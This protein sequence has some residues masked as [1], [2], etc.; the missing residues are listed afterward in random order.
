MANILRKQ[1]QM[2]SAGGGGGSSEEYTDIDYEDWVELTPTEQESGKYYIHGAPG[3]DGDISVELMTKLWENSSPTSAF[4]GQDITGLTNLNDYSLLYIKFK[5]YITNTDYHDFVISNDL[6]MHT[7]SITI[8]STIAGSGAVVFTRS[9]TPDYEN[10]KITFSNGTQCY[11]GYAQ[12]TDNSHTIPI[13]IYGIKTTA[14]AKINVIATDVSTSADKCMLSDGV[15]SVEDALDGFRF[16]AA[17][18]SIVGLVS[19][20]SPYTDSDG[21][22]ILAN[23][24]TGQ[25]MID[26]VTYKSIVSTEDTRG[27]VGADT[28]TPFKKGGGGG[29]TL[30]GTYSGN[31][32]IDVSEYLQ[33]GDTVDN[34]IVEVTGWT[35]G[36]TSQPPISSKA[37]YYGVLAATTIGKSLNGTTLSTSGM[38]ASGGMYT[39]GW[40][41]YYAT[42]SINYKVYHV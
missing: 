20:D 24:T 42:R 13:A 16:Y 19:D 23:S 37:T 17:G 31:Q 10:N 22:Y 26:N 36:S 32:T 3:A 25:S 6:N 29:A 15:T 27:T 4:A 39:S 18:T 11:T 21:N 38:S 2:I 8:G 33:S 9:I 5:N 30:I 1:N 7:I 28:A 14:T 35:S 41:T 40:G 12:N 34:F